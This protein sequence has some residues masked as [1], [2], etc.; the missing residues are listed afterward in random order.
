MMVKGV[1][2]I[3]L[4]YLHIYSNSVLFQ[5]KYIFQLEIACVYWPALFDLIVRELSTFSSI[6]LSKLANILLL[7]FKQVSPLPVNNRM[8]E[9]EAGRK[10]RMKVLSDLHP[11]FQAVRRLR[12]R[13][14]QYDRRH[15]HQT[16]VIAGT[17]NI[18]KVPGVDLKKNQQKLRRKIWQKTDHR[19]MLRYQD[20]GGPNGTCP[21]VILELHK[22]RWCRCWMQM[23]YRQKPWDN[24]CSCLSMKDPPFSRSYLK[25]CYPFGARDYVSDIFFASVLVHVGCQLLHFFIT[26]VTFEYRKTWARDTNT[27]IQILSTYQFSLFFLGFFRELLSESS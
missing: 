1:S 2:V 16:F 6:R 19:V 24:E 25:E 22:E 18:F 27:N 15:N 20:S 3:S 11:E 26:E 9:A 14:W 12:K 17:T 23:S 13:C 5:C 10:D 4:S 8:M 21:P 7:N